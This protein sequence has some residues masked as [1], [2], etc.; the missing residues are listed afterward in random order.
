M[1]R[2]H[3]FKFH[4]LFYIIGLAIWPH[5]LPDITH[6]KVKN[7]RKSFISNLIELKKF[8]ASPSLKP[9]FYRDGVARYLTR[10]A[11]SE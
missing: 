9:L 2:V 4:I 8:R 11:R 1:F 5:G 7:G 3:H 6:I 10:F